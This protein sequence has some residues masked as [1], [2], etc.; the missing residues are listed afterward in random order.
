[1]ALLVLLDDWRRDGGPDLAVVTVDHGLR[2]EAAGEAA[3]VAALCGRLG[4]PHETVNWR[5]NGR[6]NLPDAA[7]RGRMAAI[8]EWAFGRAIGCVALGHTADDQAETFLMR[9]ARGSGVDGLAG[10]AVRR[11][12]GGVEWV[13]PLLTVRREDLR[14]V[15]RARG[16]AW[17]DDPTNEDAAFDRVRA[18][19]ALG[20][21][22]PLGPS[23]ETL[24]ATSRWM[25]LAREVLEDAAQRLAREAVTVE[26]GDVV[27]A[28]GAFEAAPEETR[29][30]L[31]AGALR[32]VA[33]ADYRP[34][35]DGLSQLVAGLAAGK[36]QTLAG[37]LVSTRGAALRIGREYNAVQDLRCPVGEIWDNRWRVTGADGDGLTIRA[38]GEDGLKACPEWRAT[39]V[40]RATLL[41]TPSVW[42]GDR[43]VS[44][45]FAGQS[46]GWA[47]TLHPG[48]ADF[49]ATLVTH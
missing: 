39:G 30:R 7:R 16:M 2:P 17:V 31:L 29:L 41:A 19:E 22:G 3:G 11:R 6:G 49:P 15:L 23:A 42:H 4:V 25:A 44:A 10:M 38:L 13:R 37:C 9:L 14:E 40:P 48:R 27:I 45:P 47:A 12:S 8:A 1:M 32:W 24:V 46:A 26:A 34:R 18:R 33:S 28:R 36:P 43:L 35:L 5:W 20:V 21:L